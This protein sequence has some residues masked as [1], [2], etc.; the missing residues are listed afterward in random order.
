M[1]SIVKDKLSKIQKAKEEQRMF[2]AAVSDLIKDLPP[3][4]ITETRPDDLTRIVSCKISDIRHL[5]IKEQTLYIGGPIPVP[6]NLIT[7]EYA[8][9]YTTSKIGRR[10]CISL[11]QALPKQK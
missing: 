8:D 1:F 10:T 3:E 2:I 5:T 4:R 11:L 7:G 6:Y 9:K